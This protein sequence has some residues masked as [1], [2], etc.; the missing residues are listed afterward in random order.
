MSQSKRSAKYKICLWGF[1]LVELLVVISII[2]ILMS[3]ILPAVQSARAAGRRTDCNNRL[4]Q[5]AKAVAQFTQANASRLPPGGNGGET[6]AMFTYLLPYIEESALF[7]SIN[8]KANTAANATARYTVVPS[9]LCPEYSEDPAPR[10]ETTITKWAAGAL[11]FFQGNGGMVDST[12][13]GLISS[14]HGALPSNGAFVL[15]TTGKNLGIGLP[16]ATFRD[17][18][19][20]TTLLGEFAHRNVDGG[21]YMNF[22]GNVRAWIAGQNENT[23]NGMYAYKVVKNHDIN[24]RIERSAS[25]GDD[26]N[27]LPFSSMHTGGVHMAMVDGSTRFVTDDLD[28]VI[29]RALATRS[30]GETVNIA[31]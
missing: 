16:I 5:L 12:V 8:L 1:T 27:Y 11:L 26:F 31:P 15:N 19:S 29:Q 17:G 28:I 13:T 18:T 21:V 22:P 3:M 23:A 2:G 7:R 10:D 20:K 4:N 25:S 6:H 14:S 24:E 30:G 9:Y